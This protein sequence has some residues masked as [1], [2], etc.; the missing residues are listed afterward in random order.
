MGTDLTNDPAHCLGKNARRRFTL[1]EF[2]IG[3][4]EVTNAQYAAFVKATGYAVP[5]NWQNGNIS[6]GRGEHPVTYVS[7]DDGTAFTEWLTKETGRSFDFALKPS[8]RKPAGTAGL[9]YPWGDAFNRFKANTFKSSIGTITPVGNYSPSGDSPY[10][11]SDM[12][13]NA[14]ESVS[15]LA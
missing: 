15:R 9:I 10:G 4:Y 14:W 8:G 2:Y 13:G 11:V 3:K 5:E 7:W 12:A 1:P 6:T